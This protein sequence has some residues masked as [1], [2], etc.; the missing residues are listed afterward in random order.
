MSTNRLPDIIDENN[1]HDDNL[2]DLENNLDNSENNNLDDL[3]NN[4]PIER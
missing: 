2:N 1:I 4:K 3:E